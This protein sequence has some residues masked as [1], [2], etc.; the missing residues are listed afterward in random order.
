[1]NGK[2]KLTVTGNGLAAYDNGAGIRGIV[3][4]ATPS[5]QAMGYTINVAADAAGYVQTAKGVADVAQS[6]DSAKVASQLSLS[7]AFG[8]LFG[9]SLGLAVGY[10]FEKVAF[11][12]ENGFG[13]GLL[14]PNANANLNYA[15]E[16]NF[17]GSPFH[18]DS[19]VNNTASAQ[20]YGL[21]PN[22]RGAGFVDPRA[23]PATSALDQAK[24]QQAAHAKQTIASPAQAAKAAAQAEAARAAEINQQAQARLKRQEGVGGSN[25]GVE[26][27]PLSSSA[28]FFDVESD[29]YQERKA[30][31]SFAKEVLYFLRNFHRKAGRVRLHVGVVA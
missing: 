31:D 7:L 16:F 11:K 26:L 4:M 22:H 5:T 18:Q 2:T 19:N 25:D 24:A 13:L 6:N 10:G 27:R 21:T 28:P 15:H 23:L 12:D 29:P 1:M 3:N 17:I 8:S 14:E 30:W 20:S 9:G